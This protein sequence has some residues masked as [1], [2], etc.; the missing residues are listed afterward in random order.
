MNIFILSEDPAE[1]AQMLCDKHAAG[2]M[3]VESAQML[4]TAHRILDGTVMRAPSK[5]GKTMSR[6]WVHPN[7]NLDDVLYK[8]VHV[9]HPCTVWTMQND[10]NYIWH[11]A[12]F[13]ALCEEYTY[14]YGKIHSSQTLLLDVLH[15]VP[16]N[17]PSG[18]LTKQPLAMQSNPECMFPNDVVKS[19]R[20]FYQTKQARFKMAW[21]KRP[22]PE[23]FDVKELEVA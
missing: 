19:Y 21:T 11:W 9:G 14:R 6:H 22:I 5:S 18:K 10:S 20:S 7:A 4:S 15:E 2:K 3:A 17:I 1:A 16:R 23:W 13:K 8:A 12:H